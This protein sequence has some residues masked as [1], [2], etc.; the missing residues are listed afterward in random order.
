MWKDSGD[1]VD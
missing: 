1:S